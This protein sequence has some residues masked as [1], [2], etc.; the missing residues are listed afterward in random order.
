[1]DNLGVK[2]TY[3]N[4]KLE[5]VYERTYTLQEYADMVRMDLLRLITDVEELVYEMNDG[6]PR[7]EWSDKSMAAFCKVKHKL[8][9]KAGDIGRL[10]VNIFEMHKR[11]LTD[12]V[13]DIV[14]G[15]GTW[16]K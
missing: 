6:K 4:E 2:I 8:L 5:P 1:M 12:V 3:R 14:N 10:P 7:E 15:G 13:A 11:S 9:D 16:D